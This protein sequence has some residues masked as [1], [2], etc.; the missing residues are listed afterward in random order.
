MRSLTEVLLGVPIFCNVTLSWWVSGSWCSEGSLDSHLQAKQSETNAH[1][2]TNC[3]YMGV[4]DVVN[5][6]G[7]EGGEPVGMVVEGE[8][9]LC[10]SLC[11]P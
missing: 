7:R 6:Y 5:V 8:L 9:V 10:S 2:E 3:M 4:V 1:M 11:M